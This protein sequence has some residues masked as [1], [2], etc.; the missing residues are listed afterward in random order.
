VSSTKISAATTNTKLNPD[1]TQQRALNQLP[2]M[3]YDV[4]LS[5]LQTAVA[6]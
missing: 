5:P 6:G 1:K 4:T 3:G 2:Q